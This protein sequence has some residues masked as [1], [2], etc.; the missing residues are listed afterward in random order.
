[1]EKTFTFE[2]GHITFSN[3]SIEIKDKSSRHRLSGILIS[4]SGLVLA[5]LLAFNDQDFGLPFWFYASL[6]I[7]NV[8]TII[9]FLLRSTKSVI[10]RADIKDIRVKK[11]LGNP[12]LDIKLNNFRIRRVSQILGIESELREYIQRHSVE[13]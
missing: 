5:S 2:E 12:F 13:N 6:I 8:V 7:I 4:A 9:L 3:E 11:A 10:P 1:M